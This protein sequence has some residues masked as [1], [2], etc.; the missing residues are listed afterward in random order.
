VN[1]SQIMP[2]LSPFASK[3]GG[4]H[5]PPNGSAAPAESSNMVW[6]LEST[7]T[8]WHEEFAASLLSS[9]QEQTNTSYYECY[10]LENN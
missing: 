6:W 4:G 8:K 3:S 7:D 10:Q 1:Y 2:P 5:D 9:T